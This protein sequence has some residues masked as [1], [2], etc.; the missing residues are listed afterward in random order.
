[1][2]N[3]SRPSLTHVPLQ[4][5]R[6]ATL[7]ASEWDALPLQV[8]LQERFADLLILVDSLR[9]EF[10]TEDANP[11]LW[12]EPAVQQVYADLDSVTRKL[13]N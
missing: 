7:A 4:T 12:A 9:S 1:M 2:R 8:R 13:A 3:E 5:N 11:L 6:R 10:H